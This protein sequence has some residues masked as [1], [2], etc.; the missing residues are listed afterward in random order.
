VAWPIPV[1]QV[2]RLAAGMSAR[3]RPSNWY[4]AA[5][6]ILDGVLS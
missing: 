3:V 1:T 2:A 4:W 6:V 5:T